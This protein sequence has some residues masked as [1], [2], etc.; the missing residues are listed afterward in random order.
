MASSTY[1]DDLPDEHQSSVVREGDIEDAFI[2]KL[3][4]LKYTVRTD[5]SSARSSDT[6][7]F[8]MNKELILQ[9]QSQF[10]LL[11]QTHPEATNLEFWFA[12]DLQEPLGYARWQTFCRRSRLPPRIWRRR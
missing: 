3:R 10:D 9:M 6:R 2:E 5:N 1:T 11:A 12:R 8:H 4:S 7:T